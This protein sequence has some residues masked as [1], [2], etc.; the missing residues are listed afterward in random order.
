[1]QMIDGK[2][3]YST[4]PMT[5]PPPP[6]PE[7]KKKRKRR[8][9]KKKA[10]KVVRGGALKRHPSRPPA[11]KRVVRTKLVAMQGHEDGPHGEIVDREG[12]TL[13]VKWPGRARIYSHNAR[14]MVSVDNKED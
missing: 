13:F 10:Q 6:P 3:V 1:M 7:N 12:D 4:E 5:A 14:Y 2:L 9:K 8:A 11:K